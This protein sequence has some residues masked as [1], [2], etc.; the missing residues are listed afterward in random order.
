MP[1]KIPLHRLT[2]E[3]RVERAMKG[4]DSTYGHLKANALEFI[5]NPNSKR[6]KRLTYSD[7]AGFLNRGHANSAHY[8]HY[9]DNIPGIAKIAIPADERVS[10][11]RLDDMQKRAR[12]IDG[13]TLVTHNDFK[14]GKPL[15]ISD[16]PRYL[17]HRLISDA[18]SRTAIGMLLT[19]FHLEGFIEPHYPVIKE[20][21]GVKKI[22]EGG[23]AVP[24]ATQIRVKYQKE[25][26]EAIRRFREKGMAKKTS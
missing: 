7:V 4:F 5:I 24:P 9:I 12:E 1:R 6:K 21:R 25:L 2:G 22:S 23:E 11:D 17:M 16:I 20:A 8:G 18:F 19:H 26:A 14:Y 15:P 13:R 10:D 3:G